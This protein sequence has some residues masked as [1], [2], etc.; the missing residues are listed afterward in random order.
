MITFLNLPR[1]IREQIY[2]YVLVMARIFVRPF[3]SMDYLFDPNRVETYGSPTLSLL[4]VCKQI[5][6][7]A[8]PIYLR[9]NTFSIVHI[10]LLAAACRELPRIAHNLASIRHL[11]LVFDCRDYIYFSQFVAEQ[12]PSIS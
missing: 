6:H 11:E 2:R 1:P 9:E 8:T 3:I 10:D 5:H 4:S 7:E 12:L